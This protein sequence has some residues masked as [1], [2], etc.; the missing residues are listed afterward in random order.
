MEIC[1][2]FDKEKILYKDNNASIRKSVEN[3]LKR[4]VNLTGADL[5]WANMT[6]V[7]LTGADL[8]RAALT[9]AN[10]T[11]AN[12]TGV[13]LSRANM[14]GVDLSR[15]A[16]TGAN[17]TGANMTGVDL[18]R[19]NMTGANMTGADL[20]GVDLSRANL[21]GSTGNNIEIKTIQTGIYIVNIVEKFEYLQI[22][23]ERNTIERWFNFTD[24]E[25]LEMDGKKALKWWKKWKPIL[26]AILE[27][28]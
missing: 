1:S 13:D 28:K 4:K 11:G 18:S 23:C 15:A 10:M 14:T 7:N 22:G 9:G 16:L 20:T 12:M 2:R 17:M 3:A 8:T 26:V 24:R 25:I 21:C 6:G 27:Y 5:T 19:A